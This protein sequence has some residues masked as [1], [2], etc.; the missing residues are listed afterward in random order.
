MESRTALFRIATIGSIVLLIDQLTK[1][2]IRT[3]IPLSGPIYPIPEAASFFRLTHLTNT[4]VAFGFLQGAS[5]LYLLIVS[6]I[7][8][9]VVLY[10]RHLPW[11][12]PAV[13]LAAGL[14]LGGAMGN[15]IDRV[16]QGYVTDF[17]D[18]YVSIGGKV[19][20]YPPFNLADSAIVVGVGLLMVILWR[21]EGKNKRVQSE[22][23]EQE[24]EVITWAERAE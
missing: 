7:L 14:Q 24:S 19:Y 1:A 4:G 3:N 13:Q 8:M 23:P 11:H 16:H 22:S 20:H 18:F 6:V 12:L 21:E 2:W 5:M 15:L 10:A 9:A 17:L